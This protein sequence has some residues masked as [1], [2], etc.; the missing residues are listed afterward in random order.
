MK[1]S[2]V[3]V[4]ILIY[5]IADR[6]FRSRARGAGANIRA[7]FYSCLYYAT[8][9][10]GLCSEDVHTITAYPGRHTDTLQGVSWA[11]SVLVYPY[12]WRPAGGEV[13]HYVSVDKLCRMQWKGLPKSKVLVW[14]NGVDFNSSAVP[15]APAGGSQ[16]PPSGPGV[17]CFR[18]APEFRVRLT[19]QTTF[20]IG[21]ISGEF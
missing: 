7:R 10:V 19:V 17:Y 21:M 3:S 8:R 2:L 9:P 18:F 16:S 11:K 14:E 13:R 15:V 20:A 12:S 6:I 1:V 4:H 5:E